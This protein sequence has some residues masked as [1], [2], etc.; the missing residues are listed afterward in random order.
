MRKYS[1]IFITTFLVVFIFT[2]VS[3]SSAWLISGDD[4]R[5]QGNNL[6]PLG[7][8]N[9]RDTP[10][11]VYF[12]L[13]T[14]TTFK[15]E[16]VY[17]QQ[18]APGLLNELQTAYS[19]IRFGLGRFEDYPI[20]PFGYEPS[21]DQ[22]YQ[23]LVDLNPDE[24]AMLTAVN[25]IRVRSGLDVPE[26]Q[27]PAVYQAVTGEGQDLSGLG[28]A[29]AGILPGQQ[30]NFRAEAVNIIVLWTD[31][32]FH[33]P[34]DEGAIGY[35]GS[36]FAETITAVRQACRCKVVGVYSRPDEA[37][38][39]VAKIREL[40]T[41]RDMNKLVRGTGAL[42]LGGGVDCDG[43]GDSDIPP[44]KPLVCILDAGGQ[45]VDLAMAALIKAVPVPTKTYLPAVR[46]Q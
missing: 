37:F 12:L 30:A 5:G 35:P 2:F 28:Y 41:L 46:S 40:A 31:A 43:D 34:G 24:D 32:P 26:S 19:D 9:E 38:S 21:G 20:I 39:A 17:F 6:D 3:I 45:G 16:I 33:Q 8:A 25:A 44:G 15:G 4:D 18:A 42:A 1:L 13:D 36:S 23:R 7:L 27:L 11:D 10:R 29:A 22:A 14:T